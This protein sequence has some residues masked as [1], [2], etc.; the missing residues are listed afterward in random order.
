MK[1][2]KLLFRLSCV[3]FAVSPLSLLLKFLADYKGDSIAVMFAVL[4]GVLFY[5]GLIFGIVFLILV[6]LGRKRAAKTADGKIKESG[7]GVLR[8]F[9][10]R[11]AIVFDVA[12]VVLFILTVLSAVNEDIRERFT[13]VLASFLLMTVYMHSMFNGMNYKY[14]KSL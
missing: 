6:N 2:D 10:N 4:T 7:V 1:R 13:I 14:I 5:G 8:F 3:A 12:M 9:S 11:T